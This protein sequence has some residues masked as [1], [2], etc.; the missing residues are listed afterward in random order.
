MD[1]RSRLLADLGLGKKHGL[2]SRPLLR[3]LG[4]AQDGSSRLGSQQPSV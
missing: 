3:A 2:K 4:A 1:L